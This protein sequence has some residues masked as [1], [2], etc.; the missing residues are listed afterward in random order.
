MLN[1]MYTSHRLISYVSIYKK[2]VLTLHQD[3]IFNS[4]QLELPELNW[5]SPVSSS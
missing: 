1:K 2:Q 3:S 4:S 5:F